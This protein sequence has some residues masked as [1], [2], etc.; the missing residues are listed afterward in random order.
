[1]SSLDRDRFQPAVYPFSA[2]VGQERMKQALILNV[3]QPGLHGVLIK[4]ERGTAKSTAVRALAA[5]LPEIPFIDGCPFGCDPTQ[6][7]E[8]L[9]PTCRKRIGRGETLRTVHRRMPIVDL[10]INATEDRLVG[11]LDVARAL[12]TG[13]QVFS[14]GILAEAHRGILYVDEVNLLNDHVMDLLLDAAA[15]G[16]N[17]VERE[18]IR[19]MH[20]SRFILVGTMNPE[21]GELRPQLTDRFDLSVEVGRVEEPAL[22]EEI[23]RRRLAFEADPAAFRARWE[24]EERR[25][26]ETLL[27]ARRSLAGVAIPEAVYR[28]VCEIA[29]ACRLDGHRAEIAAVK[30]AQALAA[31][32]GRRAVGM[33]DLARAVELAFPHRFRRRPFEEETGEVER[34]AELLERFRKPG[35]RRKEASYTE[36]KTV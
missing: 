3:V 15:M 6:P 17:I 35:D 33:E 7:P 21:E 27:K 14:P 36:K 25:L 13:E 22:R 11:T 2:L 8:A 19:A 34:L 12:E 29:A 4:G 1:M 26:A 5:L 16:V 31:M 24:G 10:P 28:V 18:G 32:A 20:P 9:C 23:V 30:A